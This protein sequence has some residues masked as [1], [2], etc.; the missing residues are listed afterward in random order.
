M[1]EFYAAKLILDDFSSYAKLLKRIRRRS[2]NLWKV[3]LERA[4]FLLDQ[5]LA[6]KR[7]QESGMVVT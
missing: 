4:E 1:N 6:A 3:H 7:V 2:L 5:A